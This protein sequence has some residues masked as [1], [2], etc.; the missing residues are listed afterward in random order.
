MSLV[1]FLLA[2]GFHDERISHELPQVLGLNVQ[3]EFFGQAFHDL[4]TAVVTG[5]NDQFRSRVPDLLGLHPP[6]VD[7]LVRIRH[8]PRAA[9]CAAAIVVHPVRIHVDNVL[10]ALLGDPP[11]LF[12]VAVAE[13]LLALP[14]VIAGIMHGR[15][16]LVNG[17]IQF[18]S[19]RLNVFFEEI[20]NGDDFVF[21]EN[22]GVPILQT[23][24]GRIVGVPSLG[25]EKR[26][27]LQPLHVLDNTTDK[28][29]HGLVIP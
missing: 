19:S 9:A 22:F 20:V 13:S 14:A 5:R 8:G 7:S 1:N 11:R 10:A 3:A 26:L 23:K 16:F 2:P 4:V 21:L 28:R 18:D 24:P 17:F 15:E 25:Q 12:K 29:L 6:I 27:T